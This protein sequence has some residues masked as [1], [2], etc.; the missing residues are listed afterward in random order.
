M[1][2]AERAR[3]LS[4]ELQKPISITRHVVQEEY[5][6]NGKTYPVAE[7]HD[8]KVYKVPAEWDVEIEIPMSTVPLSNEWLVRHQEDLDGVNSVI[9]GQLK[10]IQ[11]SIH[12]HENS[13][14]AQKYGI[15]SPLRPTT[16]RLMSYLILY[17]EYDTLNANSDRKAKSI[18]EE[19]D[20]E[21][22]KINQDVQ[23]K[24]IRASGRIRAIRQLQ[25]TF[26]PR[27]RQHTDRSEQAKII[28]ELILRRAALD[29]L[30]IPV[31]DQVSAEP[32]DSTPPKIFFFPQA[33][34]DAHTIQKDTLNDFMNGLSQYLEKT[35]DPAL[36]TRYRYK[37]SHGLTR[38]FQDCEVLDR[39]MTMILN[40]SQLVS[41]QEAFSPIQ[42]LGE[43]SLV[44]LKHRAEY[45]SRTHQGET[46]QLALVYDLINSSLSGNKPEV[47]QG[48]PDQIDQLYGDEQ[49][50]RILMQQL[51]QRFSDYSRG[52]QQF[53]DA[54]P[55]F[56]EAIMMIL[57]TAHSDRVREALELLPPPEE[58]KKILL[59]DPGLTIDT[60]AVLLGLRD[61]KNFTHPV[62]QSKILNQLLKQFN[63]DLEKF[64]A[65]NNRELLP[66]FRYASLYPYY[67]LYH[68]SDVKTTIRNTFNVNLDL[69][70]EMHA[71]RGT[72]SPTSLAERMKRL[73]QSYD[74]IKGNT[75]VHLPSIFLTEY[76]RYFIPDESPHSE[77]RQSREN[78]YLWREVTDNFIWFVSPR[79]DLFPADKDKEQE[80]RGID[81]I[82]FRMHREHPREY[83]AEITFS[84]IDEP[85]TLWFD[86][87]K[88]ILDGDHRQLNVD[89]QAM[90]SFSNFLLKRLYY[91]TS[92]I[93]SQDQEQHPVDYGDEPNFS[94]RRAHFTILKDPRFHMQ[95]AQARRHAIELL[96]QF[97]INLKK[98]QERRQ[99]LQMMPRTA[100][101]TFTRESVPVIQDRNILPNVLTYKG[102]LIEI[103]VLEEDSS[104]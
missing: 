45:L 70:N 82:K 100:H 60:F 89:P 88:R 37:Y 46:L 15:D 8:G 30:G 104:L 22:D 14:Y 102:E 20:R 87:H 78:E 57:N 47:I 41:D 40:P 72:I 36:F 2:I 31:E 53:T 38:N 69:L 5:T 29:F 21:K 98:E 12:D 96:E 92:G 55:D 32:Q 99:D 35:K 11:L 49:D 74:E 50:K 13:S 83:S 18:R 42:Q 24:K 81:K 76:F 68:S 9:D 86:T 58:L 56:I 59:D 34:E 64:F 10:G 75:S 4:Q 61:H 16:E 80:V 43:S 6:L 63:G 48:L 103:P 97:N 94:Y 90:A 77:R 33:I 85:I 67:L 91:I 66:I 65:K 84:Q 93:L 44:F 7:E 17:D 62:L 101:L 71:Q 54:N 25:D 27:I 23:A 3:Q 1:S 79:G 51:S 39:I 95:S 28:Q 73:K 19:Y 26:F 52:L